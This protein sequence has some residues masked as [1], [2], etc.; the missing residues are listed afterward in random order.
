M[1]DVNIP[2]QAILMGIILL[3]LIIVGIYFRFFYSPL[4]SPNDFQSSNNYVPNYQWGSETANAGSNCRGY[5]FGIEMKTGAVRCGNNQKET[6]YLYMQS[7]TYNE[8]T[9]LKTPS[10]NAYSCVDSDQI[11]AI[12]VTRVCNKL[13]EGIDPNTADKSK[14][15]CPRDDGT[16][17]EYGEEYTYYTACKSDTVISNP[18]YCAGS[19]AGVSIGFQEEGFGYVPCLSYEN[20]KLIISPNCDLSEKSQQFRIVRT[21]DPTIQPIISSKQ[22]AAGNKGIYMAIIHRDTGLCL[23]PQTTTNKPNLGSNL[24]LRNCSDNNN[25]F[26]WA[27]IPSIVYNVDTN[28]YFYPESE[29]KS[30]SPQQL[31]YIGAVSN[32]QFK[33]EGDSNKLGNFLTNYSKNY[34]LSILNDDGVPSL[35]KY[36]TC[37][38]QE[39]SGANCVNCNNLK[40]QSEIATILLYNTLVSRC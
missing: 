29:L 3:V 32:P 20:G 30:T 23:M 25:G 8:D 15:W 11:N 36:Q 6:E 9:L 4:V 19:I 27:M 17:A 16:F 18:S 5:E 1:A 34:T 12:E 2:I 24:S 31:V 35:G 37:A 40:Y 28:G 21:T 38:Y 39:C 14:T 10:T 13:V 26:I 33:L 7:P 22:G